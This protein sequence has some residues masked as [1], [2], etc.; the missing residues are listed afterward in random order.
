MY[1]RYVN[2]PVFGEILLVSL[3]GGFLPEKRPWFSSGL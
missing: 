1:L 2:S 3:G